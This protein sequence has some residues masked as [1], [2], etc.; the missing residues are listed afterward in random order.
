MQKTRSKRIPL[1]GQYLQNLDLD[2][3]G[4]YLKNFKNYQ[5]SRRKLFNEHEHKIAGFFLL[6]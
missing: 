2:Q 1:L 5:K 4:N 3:R 6:R